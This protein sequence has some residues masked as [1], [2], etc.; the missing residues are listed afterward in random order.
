MFESRRRH[1]V[2]PNFFDFNRI[3]RRLYARG[4]EGCRRQ[5]QDRTKRIVAAALHARMDQLAAVAERINE[6][7]PIAI[8]IKKRRAFGIEV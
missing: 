7:R 5:R 4:G 1:Q 2:L 6:P 3:G 8:V